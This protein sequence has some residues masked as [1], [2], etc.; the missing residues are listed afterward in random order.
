MAVQDLKIGCW[1]FLRKI[2]VVLNAPLPVE[3]RCKSHSRRNVQIAF[4]KSSIFLRIRHFRFDIRN[5]LNSIVKN[6]WVCFGWKDVVFW[7]GFPVIVGFCRIFRIVGK[8]VLISEGL[9]NFVPS[10]KTCAKS[11]NVFT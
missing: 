6:I 10:F 11:L 5:L 3:K 8:G 9:F 1:D 4:R 7:F 2:F